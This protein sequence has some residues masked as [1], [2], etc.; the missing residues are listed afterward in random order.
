MGKI[1]Q[2]VRKTLRILE[3]QARKSISDGI[4][5][6]WNDYTIVPVIKWSGLKKKKTPMKELLRYMPDDYLDLPIVNY[7]KDDSDEPLII[8]WEKDYDDYLEEKKNPGYGRFLCHNCMIDPDAVSIYDKDLHKIM[9]KGIDAKFPCGTVDVFHCP[10]EKEKD[11]LW[12]L[13]DVYKELSNLISSAS[14]GQN[15]ELHTIY[16]YPSQSRYEKFEN[17]HHQSEPSTTG[18]DTYIGQLNLGY[19]PIITLEDKFKL[20]TDKKL[21]GEFFDKKI[22]I[23]TKGKVLSEELED[24]PEFIKNLKQ[25]ALQYFSLI[26]PKILL[27][28]MSDDTGKYWKQQKS[29]IEEGEKHYEELAIKNSVLKQNREKP[30]NGYCMKCNKFTNI[31]CVECVKWI[32]PG[33]YYEHKSKIHKIKGS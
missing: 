33:H 26:K 2:S 32:C 12:G 23:I 10:Y 5:N 4:V 1:D 19:R 31:F 18:P 13:K 3:G 7:P 8:K 29:E 24:N 27:E 6:S 17:L 30:R 11:I 25:F 20:L 14:K 9:L 16:A 15:E 28:E 21:L 22:E